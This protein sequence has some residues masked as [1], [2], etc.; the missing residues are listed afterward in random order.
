MTIVY[1]MLSSTQV[2]DLEIMLEES[3]PEGGKLC[4]TAGDQRE[5]ADL[6]SNYR[7]VLEEGEVFLQRFPMRVLLPVG[8]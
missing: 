1:L 8:Q 5:P 4:I 2:S 6:E 3:V 7:T